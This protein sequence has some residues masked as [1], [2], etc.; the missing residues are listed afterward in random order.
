MLEKFI[1]INFHPF[2]K[3]IKVLT[4]FHNLKL[5]EMGKKNRPLGDLPEPPLTPQSLPRIP[6]KSARVD[7]KVTP[8]RLK[9][10]PEGYLRSFEIMI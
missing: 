3:E 8:S 1:L 2:P 5:H 9:S 6:P 7:P 4:K 10:H